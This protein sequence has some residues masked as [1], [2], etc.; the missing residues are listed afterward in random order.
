MICYIKHWKH[1]LLHFY[2]QHYNI[3]NII[4]Y[5][6]FFININ[7]LL[8]YINHHTEIPYIIKGDY[9]YREDVPCLIIPENGNSSILKKDSVIY[10]NDDHF[11]PDI[12]MLQALSETTTFEPS[13]DEP[14]QPLFLPHNPNNDS[15]ININNNNPRSDNPKAE[16]KNTESSSSTFKRI[17]ENKILNCIGDQGYTLYTPGFNNIESL[18]TYDIAEVVEHICT[19]L[20]NTISIT[21]END[22]N[23][24]NLKEEFHEYPFLKRYLISNTMDGY[25]QNH[26]ANQILI[27]LANNLNKDP[28]YMDL[29]KMFI[30]ENIASINHIDIDD[31]YANLVN[32]IDIEYIFIKRFINFT[33]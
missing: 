26:I 10:S 15:E 27:Y 11:M 31:Y 7:I 20:R 29:A 30:A 33:P 2:I 23:L 28:L 4:F 16:N 24:N 21:S 18:I 25:N 17:F 6:V 1:N 19:Y 3:I 32:L 14:S 8:D 22:L 5:I 12:A 9:Y 13:N